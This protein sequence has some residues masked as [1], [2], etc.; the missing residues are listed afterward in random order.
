L[1]EKTAGS[2]G[3]TVAAMHRIQKALPCG[4]AFS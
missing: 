3:G 2:P 1:P 4:G